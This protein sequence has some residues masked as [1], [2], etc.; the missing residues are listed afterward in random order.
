MDTVEPHG[1][2]RGFSV[3]KVLT[4][5]I[6]L[7]GLVFFAVHSFNNVF[8]N[9]QRQDDQFHNLFAFRQG[10]FGATFNHAAGA[11]RPGIFYY[12]DSLLS[13][14]EWSSTVTIN[15]EEQELW[16]T[17]HSYRI[18]EKKHTIYNTIRGDTWQ[19]IQKITLVNNHTTAVTFSM[20]AH[21]QASSG[22][23]TQHFVFA[24]VH[25]HNFWLEQQHR[26]NSFICQ[27][28]LGDPETLQRTLEKDRPILLGTLALSLQ[29]TLP[30]A[31]SLLITDAHS[32]IGPH[33]SWQWNRLL[34]TE[35]VVNNPLPLH[36]IDLGTETITFQPNTHLSSIF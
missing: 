5:C 11:D 22:S 27:V 8:V 9:M 21:L 3:I 31:P 15:G 4:P 25:S 26:S 34:T 28:M 7:V 2:A 1:P 10:P 19:L 16:N 6:L 13:Y 23:N 12:N 17:D 35:Y 18:D 33:Q 14:A 36:E 29:S 30:Q 20:I 32:V 24:I